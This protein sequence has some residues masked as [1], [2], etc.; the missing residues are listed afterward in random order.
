MRWL[1]VR[2][3]SAIYFSGPWNLLHVSASIALLVGGVGH[4][5]NHMASVR[6]I[7]ALGV[8]MKWVGLVEFLRCFE[9]TG[10]LVRIVMVRGAV[11]A[12][13]TL[14]LYAQLLVC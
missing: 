12:T 11:A 10:S 13:M 14:I 4:F 7:G 3:G 2:E 1:Q 9:K 8:T 5:T 6:T